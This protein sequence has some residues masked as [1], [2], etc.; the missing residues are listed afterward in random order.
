M[1]KRRGFVKVLSTAYDPVGLPAGYVKTAMWTVC[2]AF[3]Q[4]THIVFW[5]LNSLFSVVYPRHV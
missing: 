2:V 1:L 5:Q 4:S 3:K